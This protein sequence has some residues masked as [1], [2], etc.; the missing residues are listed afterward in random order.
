VLCDHSGN[1]SG[2]PDYQREEGQARLVVVCDECGEAQ[3]DVGPLG[4]AP[5][6]RRFIGYLAEL[7]AREL[8]LS[9][10]TIGRVRLAAMICDV[11]T[12]QI[13]PEIFKKQG[14][15]SD[16]E[17]DQVRR[18]P[19]LAAEALSDA[20]FD[21]I[22]GWVLCQRER[23]DGKGYPHGLS[24]EEIPLES[25]ILSVAEAYVAM[26]SVRPYRPELDHED[27]MAEL[28]RCAGSQFDPTVVGAFARASVRCGPAI[29]AV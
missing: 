8:G 13:S 5:R 9:S 28:S 1:Y 29:P 26:T 15:L 21:D 22:R 7:I 11:G 18:M 24:G 4:Y 20:D 16:D 2:T 17:W 23:P 27:A 19:E 6:A 14:P 10:D 25:R 3:N 12:D